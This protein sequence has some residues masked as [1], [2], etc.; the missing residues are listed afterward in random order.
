MALPHRQGPPRE[1]MSY[2]QGC[3]DRDEENERLRAY[4]EQWSANDMTALQLLQQNE[5]LRAERDEERLSYAVAVLVVLD[6]SG[7]VLA[8]LIDSLAW[9]FDGNSA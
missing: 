3:A 1:A 9:H 7:D 8:D 5:R 2:C 4:L 6:A